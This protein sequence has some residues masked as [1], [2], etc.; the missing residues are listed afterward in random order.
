M[1]SKVLLCDPAGNIFHVAVEIKNHE[2]FFTHGWNAVGRFYGLLLGGWARIVFTGSDI[3]LMELRDR[4]DQQVHYP[5]P[6]M[7]SRI[8]GPPMVIGDFQRQAVTN[9]CDKICRKPGIFFIIEKD[10]T[11]NDLTTGFLVSA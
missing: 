3:F 6:A 11:G 8:D 1:S 2:A 4:L 5:S 9:H 10:L 7:F